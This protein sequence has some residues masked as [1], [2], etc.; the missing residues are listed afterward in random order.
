MISKLKNVLYVFCYID[1]AVAVLC[2]VID[3]GY[4]LWERC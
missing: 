4:P 1:L 2:A 3:V